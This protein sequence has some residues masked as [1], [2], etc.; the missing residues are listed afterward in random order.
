[1]HMIH[2]VQRSISAVVLGGVLEKF[3]RLHIVAAE[4]EVAWLPHW[5][6]RM[7]H[8]HEKFGAM[9]DVP[10]SMPPSEYVRRQVWLT[11]LDDTLGAEAAE[12][13]GSD[14]F[15]WGSDF[16]H[17]DSTWPHSLKVIDK[18]LG[19]VQ[20]DVARKILHDN[21]AALYHIPL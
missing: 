2:E 21:A 8:A 18:N 16:P 5:M 9:M 12:R 20:R 7:D 6:Q 11:F 10:L 1:M 15:M 19:A 13:F 4:C 3:P 17:G 14:T